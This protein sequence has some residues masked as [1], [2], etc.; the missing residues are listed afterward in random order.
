MLDQ[1][2]CRLRFSNKFVQNIMYAPFTYWGVKNIPKN[3]FHPFKR[4]IL[5]CVKVSYQ[6]FYSVAI[7]YRGIG[8]LWIFPFSY[9]ST[10]TL[11]CKYLVFCY[12]NFNFRNIVNLSFSFTY[13]R[14]TI[15][16]LTTT[17]AIRRTMFFYYIRC[18]NHL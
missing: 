6:A 3:L 9:V 11:F 13:G 1:L 15:K 5:P 2:I 10:L 14:G 8:F 17:L 7:A 16:A 18:L 12:F 4:D